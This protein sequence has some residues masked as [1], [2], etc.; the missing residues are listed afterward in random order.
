[1]DV[2]CAK[3][4]R[5]WLGAL[6][7]VLVDRLARK[8]GS[9]VEQ[10]HLPNLTLLDLPWSTCAAAALRPWII[11]SDMAISGGVGRGDVSIS[12]AHLGEPALP[13]LHPVGF[14]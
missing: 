1:M 14:D 5:Y 6:D 9:M 11:S 7:S 8:E 2:V 13:R 12:S 4:R 10:R 3:G